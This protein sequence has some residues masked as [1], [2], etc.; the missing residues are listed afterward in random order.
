MTDTKSR[1][2]GDFFYDLVVK[3]LLVRRTDLF[4]GRIDSQY[5]FTCRTDLSRNRLARERP[6][7][8]KGP[9]RRKVLVP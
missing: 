8:E 6:W 5:G 3:E 4:A 7:Y 2:L 9:V 1:F